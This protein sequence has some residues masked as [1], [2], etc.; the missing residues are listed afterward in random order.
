MAV[1]MKRLYNGAMYMREHTERLFLKR[2]EDG[3]NE[4]DVFDV[5]VDDVV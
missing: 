2:K 5:I 1:R 4:L 3:V